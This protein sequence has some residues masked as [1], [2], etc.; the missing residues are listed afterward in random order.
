[1]VSLQRNTNSDTAAHDQLQS[2]QKRLDALIVDNRRL[3]KALSDTS[4]EVANIQEIGAFERTE[5]LAK[6]RDL[7]DIARQKSN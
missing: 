3:F 7:A 6:L 5:T 4:V 2:Q 1:M